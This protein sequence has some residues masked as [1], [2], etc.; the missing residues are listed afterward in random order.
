[1]DEPSVG[2]TLREADRQTNES[3]DT[4]LSGS[5]TADATAA[6]TAAASGGAIV[7]GQVD[8]IAGFIGLTGGRTH[9]GLRGFKRLKAHQQ[10]DATPRALWE[11]KA[12]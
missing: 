11:I 5:D 6:S 4:L 8:G 10:P 1:M 9:G 7:V 3:N 12:T 2:Q